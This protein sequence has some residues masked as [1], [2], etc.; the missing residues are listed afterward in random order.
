MVSVRQ[1]SGEARSVDSNEHLENRR[2]G[3]AAVSIGGGSNH[4]NVGMNS[5]VEIKFE[6]TE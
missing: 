6:I 4:G 2:G 5:F 3:R 1:V